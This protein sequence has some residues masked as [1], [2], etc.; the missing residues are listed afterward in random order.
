MAEFGDEEGGVESEGSGESD[1]SGKNENNDKSGKNSKNGKKEK[2]QKNH[3]EGITDQ[4]YAQ[5]IVHVDGLF[6][7]PESTDHYQIFTYISGR[8]VEPQTAE[9]DSY[10]G[11]ATFDQHMFFEIP[12][13]EVIDTEEKETIGYDVSDEAF[14]SLPYALVIQVI[15]EQ[16]SNV[17]QRLKLGQVTIPL[18]TVFLGQTSGNYQIMGNVYLR[19]S[20][21]FNPPRIPIVQKPEMYFC[22]VDFTRYSGE[23][24]P[25]I[26][27]VM[28]QLQQLKTRHQRATQQEILFVQNKLK[29]T[30]QR[31]RYLSKYAT[32][33]DYVQRGITLFATS[34]DGQVRFLNDF[35][36]PTPL[37]NQISSFLGL[38]TTADCVRFAISLPFVPDAVSR[39]YT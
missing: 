31:Q 20:C 5:V 38:E 12:M 36:P 22:L 17:M 1:W 32:R 37:G 35:L 29:S 11:I 24:P 16:N 27:P 3:I 18:R 21:G 7:L 28:K 9:T 4:R 14:A 25:N 13:P 6:N 2:S 26:E 30:N 34:I 33:S 8:N 10:Q 39:Y 19:V 15:Q 23:L